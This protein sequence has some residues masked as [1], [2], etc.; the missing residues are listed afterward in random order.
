MGNEGFDRSF[1]A[2]E[3]TEVARSMVSADDMVDDVAAAYGLLIKRRPELRREREFQ[4]IWGRLVDWSM[5]LEDV[6]S[7]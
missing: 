7:E 6:D 3:L 2:S 5:G 4:K 1:V